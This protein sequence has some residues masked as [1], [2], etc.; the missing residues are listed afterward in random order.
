MSDNT[1]REILMSIV[2]LVVI[3]KIAASPPSTFQGRFFDALWLASAS[4][5][6]S[7]S[8]VAAREERRRNKAER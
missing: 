6:A 2:S 3:G 4:S 8:A 5:V 7:I 1:V